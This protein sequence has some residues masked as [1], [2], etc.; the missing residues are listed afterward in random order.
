[1][2]NIAGGASTIGHGTNDNGQ[3]TMVP[4]RD[5]RVMQCNGTD[6]STYCFKEPVPST[7]TPCIK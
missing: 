5:G 3:F 7:D 6:I 4:G 2:T 1:M